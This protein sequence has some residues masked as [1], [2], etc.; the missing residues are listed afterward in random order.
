MNNIKAKLEQI[1]EFEKELNTL[2]DEEEYESFKQQQ[3]VFADQLKDFLK[4]YSQS[5]LNEEITQLKRLENLIQ[6]LQY[7]ADVD[8]K[9]LKQQSLLLQQNKKKVKAYK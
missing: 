2:L 9:K 8:A 1:F 6:K 5:E 7:R 4:K 3:D